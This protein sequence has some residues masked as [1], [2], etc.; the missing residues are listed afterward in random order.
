MSKCLDNV[1]VLIIL[2]WSKR[3][4]CAANKKKCGLVDQITENLV[5]SIVP[6]KTF[7]GTIM[8]RIFQCSNGL[9]LKLKAML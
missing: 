6:F 4:F 9:K 5:V 3:K 7:V 2:V 8:N 1:H